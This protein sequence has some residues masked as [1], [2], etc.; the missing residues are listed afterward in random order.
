MDGRLFVIVSGR[1]EVIK[2]LDGPGERLAS[3]LGPGQYFGE[4]ALVDDFIRSASIRAIG[5]VTAVSLDRWNFREAIQKHP[6]I[7][8]E[9]LQMLARR[10][11]AVEEMLI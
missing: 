5:S 7:A 2:D 11:K 10:V 3:E 4:M 6:A 8:V 9:M 1:V